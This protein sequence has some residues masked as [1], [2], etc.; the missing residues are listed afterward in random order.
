MH[1]L[2]DDV[3]G[4]LAEEGEDVSYRCFIGESAQSDTVLKVA[5][6]CRAYPQMELV[7]VRSGG[8]SGGGG[9]DSSANTFKQG[10]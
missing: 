6:G 2:V 4:V 3:T 8:S 7:M 10:L 1:P 5:R 9:C